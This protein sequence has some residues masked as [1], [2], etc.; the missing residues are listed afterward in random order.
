[1]KNTTAWGIG[2]VVLLVGGGAIALYALVYQPFIGPMLQQGR[3]LE[4]LQTMNTRIER[5]EPFTPPAD[6]Q[7]TGA[8]VERFLAVQRAV[9][10][11]VH[12]RLDS[13]AATIRELERRARSGEEPGFQ[14]VLGW[15]SSFSGA[16][17]TAKRVQVRALN[18]QD[19][20]L[21]EYRWVRTQVFQA[22][23]K[24]APPLG[25]ER[26]VGRSQAGLRVDRVMPPFEGRASEPNR[27]LI[28]PH[29]ATLDSLALIAR[30]GL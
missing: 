29:R 6:S 5:Q 2:L 21:G 13:A 25:V 14:E 24:Q 27:G 23:G 20:S 15:F 9:Y 8:Q 3:Q 7:L 1:M 22:M 16:L 26:A 10:D 4:Q 19:F 18:A 12:A 28:E 17:A 30:F 11:S